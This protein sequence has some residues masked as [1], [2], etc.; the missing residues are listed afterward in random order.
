M[1]EKLPL[2]DI[3]DIAA[4]YPFRSGLSD[5]PTGKI[6]VVQMRDVTPA[7]V[8]NWDA[9]TRIIPESNMQQ[10][11]LRDSDII[12]VMR[13]GKYYSACLGLLPMP[14]LAS[15]HFFRIRLLAEQAIDPVFLAWQLNQG[16]AQRYYSSV[17]AGTAQKSLRV[18]DLTAL[19]VH[20][21]PPGRQKKIL[22][23]VA[24]IQKDIA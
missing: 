9:T 10:Y 20:I 6:R 4:G 19:P 1:K 24:C 8:V 16:P 7:G 15:P 22:Q 21:P 11:L 13:G 23:A 14:A 18:A 2:G 12:F 5:D 3:A 17:E